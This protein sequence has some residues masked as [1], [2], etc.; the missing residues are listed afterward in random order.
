[1]AAMG[2]IP[3]ETARPRFVAFVASRARRRRQAGRLM[4]AAGGAVTV[5]GFTVLSL[6]GVALAEWARRDLSLPLPKAW[7]LP[8]GCLVGLLGSVSLFTSYSPARLEELSEFQDPGEDSLLG[9][10]NNRTGKQNLGQL[11]LCW[12]YGGPALVLGGLSHRRE[13]AG[14]S[15]EAAEA[16]AAMLYV[17]FQAEHRVS[18]ADLP[19]VLQGVNVRDVATRLHAIE[20]VLFLES[21]PAGMTLSSPLR[22][23][24]ACLT[25]GA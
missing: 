3:W 1:M 5:V 9:D 24:L 7:V 20:G 8:L 15:G 25:L 12:L 16:C 19:T 23:E 4:L 22:E 6:V 10:L 11:L 13:A 18:Y 14:L 2:S 17:L 21:A